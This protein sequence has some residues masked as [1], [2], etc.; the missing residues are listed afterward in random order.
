MSWHGSILSRSGASTKPGA[1]QSALPPRFRDF[2]YVNGNLF[3]MRSPSPRFSAKARRILL[4]CGQL[5]WSQINP[6]IFGSMIQAVVHPSQRE[7]LGMH[8]TSVENIMKVIRPLFLDELE[9]AFDSAV[10]S[11]PKLERLLKRIAV[12]HLFD[13]AC[14]SGNFLVIAYKELRRLEHKI[15]VR[16]SELDPRKASLFK[17]SVVNLESFF[18]IEID[19][20]AHEIATL[21]L[22]L[23]KHQMNAEFLELFGVE[24]PLIPLK[25]TGNIVC[26]NAVRLDW[27]EIC[28]K[29]ED[30]MTYVLGNPPYL[31]SLNRPGFHRDS[32]V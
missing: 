3:S 18:G 31:G 24:I 26:G 9:E 13:P 22:W 25:E 6:D 10:D 27:E 29:R 2:G 20:F 30:A 11:A 17:L 12:M 14:G 21:S 1:V 23:A 7:G 8:Y 16:V 28:P 32:L 4:E 5:D 19:D 15:L